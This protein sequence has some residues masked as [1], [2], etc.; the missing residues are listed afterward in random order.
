PAEVQK[1]ID[2]AL[3]EVRRKGVT[4]DEVKRARNRIETGFVAGLQAVG[5]GGGKADLLQL[6]NH[7][8][9]EPNGFGRDLARYEGVT[10]DKV[11]RFVK[12]YLQPT[13]RVVAIATPKAGKP[14]GPAAAASGVKP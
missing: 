7:F 2:V 11:Q 14:Q 1:E 9:A 8:F 3:E 10:P 6:Y 13:A 12:Q 5:G 4:A